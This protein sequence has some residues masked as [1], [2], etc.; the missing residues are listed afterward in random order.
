MD[1]SAGGPATASDLLVPVAAHGLPGATALPG[2]LDPMVASALV[3]A[4]QRERLTGPLLAA[5]GAGHVHLPAEVEGRLVDL[6]RR[7][8]ARCLQLEQRLLSVHRQLSAEGIVPVVLKGPSV[9]HLDLAD[10]AER[11]WSDVDVLV[12]PAQLDRAVAVIVGSGAERLSHTR[13]TGWDRRFGK[14]VSLR[15]DGIEVDVH[16]T[17]A[18]GVYG[19]R[20]PLD[21]LHESAVDLPLAGEDLRAL[22]RPARALH[23]AYHAV[24]GSKVPSWSNLRDLGRYLTSPD[25]AVEPVVAEARR[26][27]GEA[28]LWTAVGLVRSELG[29][30]APA[31][32]GWAD[33]QV[34]SAREER[35]VSRM[36]HGDAGVARARLDLLGEL[37]W[38]DRAA[39]IRALALPVDA[40]HPIGTRYRRWISQ[41]LRRP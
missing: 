40:P 7:A 37:G 36:R 41:L 15:V 34:L 18:E 3:S 11:T 35:L 10:P 6:H 19:A 31:W 2:H 1:A 5:V 38:S 14:S 9:A 26:W 12:R 8:L 28:V 32:Y 24:V 22:H 13:R 20:I 30:D 17:L 4:A 21:H 27:R 33:S 23:M 29:V 39:Y 16:R 25:L